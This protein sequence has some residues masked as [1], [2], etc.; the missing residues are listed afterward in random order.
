MCIAKQHYAGLK[1]KWLCVKIYL[2][3]YNEQGLVSRIYKQHFKPISKF[4]QLNKR[5]EKWAVNS[6]EREP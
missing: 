5:K 3:A 6:K 2:K 4:R 1:G